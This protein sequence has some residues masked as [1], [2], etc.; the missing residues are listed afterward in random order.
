MRGL[1]DAQVGKKFG[2][3]AKTVKAMWLH[4]DVPFETCLRFARW[5]KPYFQWVLPILIVIILLQGL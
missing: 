3:A 1:T 2:L 5:L 4:Q